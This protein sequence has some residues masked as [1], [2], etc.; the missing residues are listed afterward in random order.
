MARSA[1]G[2]ALLL[3]VA[4][5]GGDRATGEATTTTHE[6]LTCSY[7][8]PPGTKCSINV[9][10]PKPPGLSWPV[11]PV[12][13]GGNNTRLPGTGSVGPDGQY[14]Y[15]LPLDLPAGRMGLA[16]TLSLTYSSGAAN[17][18]LG[19]GWSLG[20]LSSIGPCP[21]IQAIDGKSYPVNMDGRDPL[22]LDGQRLLD[23]SGGAGTAFDT[24]LDSFGEITTFV[25]GSGARA[26]RAQSQAGVTRIYRRYGTNP[27]T[28]RG[29]F[30]LLDTVR[31]LEGNSVNY[32]YN[33]LSDT[34]GPVSVWEYSIN[35]ITYT[36]RSDANGNVTSP[37]M[38]QV[39]F[40]YTAARP[41]PISMRYGASNPDPRSGSTVQ[42][43][44]VD[45]RTSTLLSGIS[46]FGPTPTSG[47]SVSTGNCVP[48]QTSTCEP[49]WAY[50]LGYTT[51][52]A[53]GRSLLTTVTKR[54]TQGAALTR[55]FAY[56]SA[57]GLDASRWQSPVSIAPSGT[58]LYQAINI[59]GGSFNVDA[60]AS[61]GGYPAYVYGDLLHDGR[62]LVLRDIGGNAPGHITV[63]AL[64][65]G[66]LQTLNLAGLDTASLV[67]AHVADLDGDGV[68]EIVA[69]D[70]AKRLQPGLAYPGS[71]GGFAYS[72]YRLNLATKTYA[73]TPTSIWYF[74]PR[75]PFD[76][77]TYYGY[78][79]CDQN[80]AGVTFCCQTARNSSASG[81][82][83]AP[84]APTAAVSPLFLADF[85][86]SGLPTGFWA[87][88]QPNDGQ[89][90]AP[91]PGTPDLDCQMPPN[92]LGAC[93]VFGCF[94][95]SSTTT[96]WYEGC[97]NYAWATAPLTTSSA[98]PS[99]GSASPIDDGASTAPPPENTSV[100]VVG[101][102]GGGFM[103]LPG[104]SNAPTPGPSNYQ[105]LTLTDGSGVAILF[106]G[107]DGQDAITNVPVGSSSPTTLPT[108]PWTAWSDRNLP[109]WDNSSGKRVPA[110][111]YAVSRDASDPT[112]THLWLELDV[113]ALSAVGNF[114]GRAI[115][116]VYD[117]WGHLPAGTDTN[118]LNWRLRQMD[119]D[120]D[121]RSDLVAYHIASATLAGV[122]AAYLFHWGADGSLQPVTALTTIPLAMADY[123]GDGITDMIGGT[124]AMLNAG[125][126]SF[127]KGGTMAHDRVAAT[128]DQ[129]AGTPSETVT[130]VHQ[131]S[132]SASTGACGSYPTE[133][134]PGGLTVVS[135]HD[136]WQG[137]DVGAWDAR[138]YSYG[139]AR[140]DVHGRGFLGFDWIDEVALARPEETVTYYSNTSPLIDGAYLGARPTKIVHYA[141]TAPLTSS[142]ATVRATTT[143]NDW[144][145]LTT[146]GKSYTAQKYYWATTDQEYPGTV[147]LYGSAS[148]HFSAPPSSA[149]TLRTRYGSTDYDAYN[150]VT[151]STQITEGGVL[152]ATKTTYYPPDTTHFLR[153]LPQTVQVYAYTPSGSY[154]GTPRRTDYTY[155]DPA[156]PGRVHT[157]TVDLGSSD[158]T[159][160]RTTTY[161]RSLDGVV[162][163]STVTAEGVNASG[164][165]QEPPRTT[166]V[167]LDPDEGMFPRQTTDALGHVTLTLYNPLYGVVQDAFDANGIETQTTIDEFGRTTSVRSE[168]GTT[169]NTTYSQRLDS[170]QDVIGTVIAVGGPGVTPTRKVLDIRGR[171]IL[172]ET[173]GINGAWDYTVTGYD[174]VGRASVL[175]RAQGSE[176]P[177]TSPPATPGAAT[178]NVY[179]P[180][181]RLTLTTLPDLNTIS[182]VQTFLTTTTTD[183]VGNRS[184]TTRDVDGRVVQTVQYGTSANATTIFQYGDFD[185]VTQL[186]DAG[187]NVTSTTYDLRGRKRQQVDPDAGTTT[188]TYNGFGDLLSQTRAP[189]TT[190]YQHDA[191]GRVTVTTYGDGSIATNS[192]DTATMGIGKLASSTSQDGVEVDLAYD[193]LGRPAY[194][195]WTVPT[196]TGSTEYF[197]QFMTYDTD[198]RLSTTTYPSTGAANRFTTQWNYD[199][200]SGWPRSVAET[201]NG[202]TK[203]WQVGER[204]PDGSLYW[205]TNGNGEVATRSYDVNGRVLTILD[206]TSS[207]MALVDLAYAYNADGTVHTRDD[208]VANRDE[209]YAYDL[210]HRVMG[211]TLVYGSTNLQN[212][213]SYDTLGN[214]KTVSLNGSVVETD[215]YGQLAYEGT[216]PSGIYEFA[217]VHPHQLASQ[218]YGSSAVTFAYDGAGRQT[219][220]SG[221]RASVTYTDFD[222]PRSVTDAQ[223]NTTTFLYDASH[224]RIK[225]VN[226]G[227]GATTLTLGSLFE[228]RQLGNQTTYVMYVPG[229][230]G[231][232]TQVELT[233]SAKSVTY[234]HPDALG[235]TTVTTSGT[236]G[237][238]A[239]YYYDPFGYRV[240]ALGWTLGDSLQDNQIGFTAQEMDDDLTLVNMKGRIYDPRARHFLSIDPHVTYPLNPQSYDPYSYAMNDPVNRTDPT[241]F[242]P[243]G[244]N[245]TDWLNGS[246][247]TYSDDAPS[248]D[249]SA[250][251]S[252]YEPAQVGP[253]ATPDGGMGGYAPV[254]VLEAMPASDFASMPDPDGVTMP[255]GA[256]TSA[257]QVQ[258]F[259]RAVAFTDNWWSLTSPKYLVGDHWYGDP[260][261]TV[262]VGPLSF[263]SDR[264]A[265][266]P[267]EP[268]GHSTPGQVDPGGWIVGPDLNYGVPDYNPSTDNST[269]NYG[270]NASFSLL[271]GKSV[272]IG[273]SCQE[274]GA[275]EIWDIYWS[276][277]TTWTLGIPGIGVGVSGGFTFP[278]NGG[279][280]LGTGTSAGLAAG[281]IGVQRDFATSDANWTVFSP[282]A[283]AS[284]TVGIDGKGGWGGLYRA[285]TT[286][287]SLMGRSNY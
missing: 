45:V 13:S 183:P 27:A 54:A 253:T 242:D 187:G 171:T 104:S 259:E 223:Q 28:G 119:V 121:G 23:T 246:P 110:G 64:G 190:S 282:I 268:S 249:P 241:G 81:C 4:C 59:V 20:G 176:T 111:G 74:D 261:A 247:G 99:L 188:W 60:S 219:S 229:T 47:T 76:G 46:I 3:T 186:T 274:T 225:K 286:T 52:T 153:S 147:N 123:D 216:S 214:L 56:D 227:L 266:A 244:Y 283:S 195:G 162:T 135:T 139:T 206:E 204:W 68:P 179:D 210:M 55:T 124:L 237:T 209:T 136:V 22:C 193:D 108:I 262:T 203:L 101:G 38:R 126:P 39:A 79:T 116:E 12:V 258:A 243:S 228:R 5:A 7:N 86:G 131:P 197:N 192:W 30:W 65:S 257:E 180:L 145:G 158:V 212:H 224:A 80:A 112:G 97:T 211:W 94:P 221:Q 117:V 238:L 105:A 100:V 18:M 150:N 185:T 31:D 205:G 14:H 19:L 93:T 9:T 40:Y 175:S 182:R 149:T 213:Y 137:P 218:S 67:N 29:L 26:F 73:E 191:L 37:G 107:L 248:S 42:G 200:T 122:D 134:I 198:G 273:V 178:T 91:S 48:Y 133:C 120:Q 254:W 78:N 234:L 132:S 6:D 148:P 163:M 95:I 96:N 146:T 287:S 226:P 15:E 170:S 70:T 240:N 196:G 277:S 155:D 106:A 199:A 32:T 272:E 161:G 245:F 92:L 10:P 130:Y 33:N 2:G 57:A 69:P 141:P 160:T 239:R 252:S 71:P 98:G 82:P 236:G 49:V 215:S 157:E 168:A 167:V 50:T 275:G 235:T 156:H 166:S 270:I 11:T 61:P 151:Y 66:G 201:D 44:P 43:T 125:G 58:P 255:S 115:S 278:E 109:M 35:T 83:S 177:L 113:D 189:G 143:T 284:W 260:L 256:V 184:E 281:P 114:D 231:M 118:F 77:Q 103:P 250:S 173:M 84:P 271:Y 24:E 72:V 51:S 90:E 279:T 251:A 127:Y 89:G 17:G 144:T 88:H 165:Y 285:D 140:T 269:A 217:T 154:T 152:S 142:S 174:V 128:R 62:T 194:T 263:G 232:V 53:T 265:D 264:D 159:L 233:G 25:D 169:V 181:D 75:E 280:F 16:P 138:S 85:T 202:T 36:N 41:D 87:H 222:L 21:Q 8:T 208:T 63:M 34:Q 207:G 129:G 172:D 267:E 1:A 220:A 164:P 230:D 276:R 102:L